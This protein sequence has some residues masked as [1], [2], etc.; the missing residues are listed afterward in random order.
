M[1]EIKLFELPSDSHVNTVISHHNTTNVNMADRSVGVRH[2][3]HE[4]QASQSSMFCCDDVS[5]EKFCSV[6]DLVC[7]WL[8]LP[9]NCCVPEC[10]QKEVKSS[11]TERVSFFSFPQSPMKETRRRKGVHDHRRTVKVCSFRLEDLRKCVSD[12]I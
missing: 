1:F 12:L 3:S 11:T 4:S 7:F 5:P 9:L 8:A 10:H 2:E 6:V